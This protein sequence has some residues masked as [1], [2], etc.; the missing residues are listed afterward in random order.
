MMIEKF[1]Q[2][3][4]LN[5]WYFDYGRA[6][7][8]NLNKIPNPADYFLFLDPIEED[9]TFDPDTDQMQN[10]IYSGRLMLLMPSDFDRVY[11]D[12]H[13][14]TENQGKYEKYIKKCK[15]QISNISK[16]LCNQY[17]ILQWKII[18]VINLYDENFDGVLLN[19]KIRK[20]Y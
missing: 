19:F 3:A 17:D 5:D 18:E 10:T 15:H 9:I 7:F 6:D 2:I 1:K 11:N 12:Q 13:E 20:V 8:H 16:E 14:N 4:H